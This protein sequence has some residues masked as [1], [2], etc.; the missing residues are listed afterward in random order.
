MRITHPAL[1]GPSFREDSGKAFKHY[2]QYGLIIEHDLVPQD[3][4]DDL[5]A[6]AMDMP[7]AKDGT[8]APIMM[9]HREHDNFRKL[10]LFGPIV[11]IIEH[12]CRGRPSGLGG[13]YY[14]M[15]PETPGFVAH[16]D[17]GY[18]Q[19]P[20]DCFV[21]AWTALTDVTPH[22]G[23]LYFYIGSHKFGSLPVNAVNGDPGPGQDPNARSMEA[24]LPE[25]H[26][27]PRVD[28]ELP[29][30]AVAFF[31]SLTVHG[32]HTNRSNDYRHALLNTYIKS[33]EPFRAGNR[34]KREEVELYGD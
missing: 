34:A 1:N 20:P 26:E 7:S 17:N 13:E 9:P 14:Y 29:K 25:S 27:C 16:Q 2:L 10:M 4:C 19:A 24:V 32:S 18:V 6:T 15:K 33:G 8:C 21:S 3:M 23:G 12:L 22:N 11:G 30:G 28:V 5:I 31:H